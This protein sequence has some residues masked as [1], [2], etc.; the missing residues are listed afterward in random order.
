MGR[1]KELW[2]EMQDEAE[3]C[4]SDFKTKKECDAYFKPKKKKKS[5]GTVLLTHHVGNGQP[6]SINR[7]FD[8]A[9]AWLD[10]EPWRK[11]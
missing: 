10:D 1:M 9:D 5:T 7:P 2:Q 4:P 6:M 8:N 11:W 3:P